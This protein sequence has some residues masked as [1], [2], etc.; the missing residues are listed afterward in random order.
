[1]PYAGCHLPV[2][3]FKSKQPENIGAGQ[4][5]SSIHLPSA[6]L[7]DLTN[8]G[9]MHCAGFTIGRQDISGGASMDQ[10][11]LDIPA[12]NAPKGALK[13]LAASTSSTT[14]PTLLQV[15]TD[16]GSSDIV[17]VSSAVLASSGHRAAFLT[18]STSLTASLRS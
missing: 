15:H 6:L 11:G 12:R 16:L 7:A 1:M 9:P 13:S 3:G 2:R 18:R 17:Y 5:G 8:M 14:S 10:I 4:L